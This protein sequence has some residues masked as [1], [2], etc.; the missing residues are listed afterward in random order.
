LHTARDIAGQSVNQF[1]FAVGALAGLVCA[2]TA[3]ALLWRFRR[4][5]HDEVSPYGEGQLEAF[6]QWPTTALIVDPVSLRFG[7]GTRAAFRN[8]GH[9]VDELR[10]LRF[11]DRFSVEGLDDKSLLQKVENATNRTPI[12]MRQ[13]C[14]DGSQR[15]VE[16]TCYR[17]E[18]DSRQ[19]L[20]IAVHDVTVRR[21]VETQLLEKHQQLD[22]LAHHDHLTGLPNRLYLAAHLPDAIDQAKNNGNKL[23]VLFLDLDRFKHVNDSRGH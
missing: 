8:A 4:Q 18:F 9:W 6:E 21:K 7:A 16:A 10:G 19:G 3:F 14:R 1:A 22:H 11:G 5:G 17:I 13:R 20:A 15:N 2:A 23:A 12:E